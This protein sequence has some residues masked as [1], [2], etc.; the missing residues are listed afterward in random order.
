LEQYARLLIFI[1]MLFVNLLTTDR[2]A[3]RK[4]SKSKTALI[5]IIY[6]I[7]LITIIFV[8]KTRFGMP[9]FESGY[10]ILF[11]LTYFIP[12]NFLYQEK[13]DKI[14]AIMTF[15]WLHTMTVTFLAI[16]FSEAL[17]EENNFTIA[18]VAQTVIYVFSTP[19]VIRYVK[20]E[21]LYLLKNIPKE[22][23]RYLV[24]L[25]LT[26]F[27]LQL[28]I[29]VLS[30]D[31]LGLLWKSLTGLL[32]I[33]AAG[34][35]YHFL[36]VIVKSYRSINYLKSLA[37]S[38]ALTGIKNR[39]VLFFD[40]EKL[41]ADKEPFTL[42]FMDLDNFKQ[43]NDIYGHSMGDDYLQ[44]FTKS[45]LETIGNRGELYRMSGDEFICIYTGSKIL[46]FLETFNEKLIGSF[47]MG[48]PFLGVSIG[49]ARFPEDADSLES[50][51]NKADHVMYEVKK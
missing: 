44:H 2:S 16:I 4:F 10:L 41:I 49:Y 43:V 9:Y 35:S 38:D 7:F 26:E 23:I 28:I 11:G 17:V 50:L 15:S 34:L 8:I 39:L 36:Y 18:L 22:M 42:I 31:A 27:L 6:T 51:I 19:V 21:F 5:L 45:T 3:A 24:G 48:I 30:G 14:L 13:A 20:K 47:D 40:C 29:Y 25:G 33:I 32:L 1:S 37:Y 46:D 12:L